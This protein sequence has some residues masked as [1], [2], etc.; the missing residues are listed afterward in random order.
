MHP[1]PHFPRFSKIK[2][3]DK[4]K[5][6]AQPI[7]DSLATPHLNELRKSLE[8]NRNDMKTPMKFNEHKLQP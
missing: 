1:W 6:R 7:P 8:M 2:F 4:K 3:C 5:K